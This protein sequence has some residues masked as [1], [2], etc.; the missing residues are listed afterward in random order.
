MKSIDPSAGYQGN[1]D[2]PMVLFETYYRE[3]HQAVYANI[4]KIV[5]RPEV[6]EDVLQ[7]VF[8]ALWENWSRL[9]PDR[10]ANW[11][12]VVSYNKSLSYLKKKQKRS[13]IEFAD[14]HELEVF[15]E[16]PEIDEE[17]FEQK[18]QL[19]QEAIAQLPDRK[20]IIFRKYRMEGKSLEEIAAEMELSVHTVKDHLKIANKLIKHYLV[21]KSVHFSGIELWLALTLLAF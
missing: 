14:G 6:A 4:L 3:F 21:D 9:E 10:V 5:I 13:F 20:R 12:F 8:I 17:V 15:A 2:E 1:S 11:L 18:L 19:V 7:E 16:V